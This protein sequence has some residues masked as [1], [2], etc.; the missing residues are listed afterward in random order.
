MPSAE[1]V[2]VQRD[3]DTLR[4]DG[5]LLTPSIRDAWT[6]ALPMLGG[7]LTPPSPSVFLSPV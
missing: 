5:D 3:A 7:V 4:F 2:S 6:R 1:T